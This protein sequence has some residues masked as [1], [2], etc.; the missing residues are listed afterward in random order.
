M[1]QWSTFGNDCVINAGAHR[2]EI[3]LPRLHV[4]AQ[5]HSY[6][7]LEYDLPDNED[8]HLTAGIPIIDNPV[9]MGGIMVFACG[10]YP[11]SSQP[12]Y[13]EFW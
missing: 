12:Y 1:R 6:I 10:K 4:P 5:E 2:L 13:P 8:Y 3:R 9:T 7:C 11:L